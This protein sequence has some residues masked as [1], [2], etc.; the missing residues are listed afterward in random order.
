ML[1]TEFFPTP[2]IVIRDMVH[3]LKNGFKSP[4]LEPHG[5]SGAILDY[6]TNPEAFSGFS[7]AVSR[8]CYTIEIDPELRLILQGKGYQVIGS[9]FLDYSE[10]ATFN[11][12]LMN[13]PFSNG[14]KHVMKGWS[15]LNDGGEMVALLNAETVNNPYSQDRQ[16]LVDL[17]ELYG[18][19]KSLGQC[20]KDADRTTNVEV[21]CIWL[22]K[23]KSESAFDFDA[24]KFETDAIGEEDFNPN[25]LAFRDVVKDLVARYETC[26][27]VLQERH[28][29]QKMLNACLQGISSNIQGESKFLS[30]EGSFN[31]QLT[32]LKSRFWNTVFD[33]TKIGQKTT[34]KYRD[35]FHQAAKNQAHMAFTETNIK[36]LLMMFMC[37]QQSIM[38]ECLLNVFDEATRFHAKNIVH[39]E[40]WVTNKSSR[41]NKRIIHPY[42]VNYEKY[43]SGRFWL[44]VNYNIDSFLYDMDKV[45]CW[46][47]GKD[48][49]FMM[50]TRRVLDDFMNDVQSGKR[51]FTDSCESMFFNMRIY[52]KGTLHLD[53]KDLKLLEDFNR[54]VAKGKKW[55]GSDY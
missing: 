23:P 35:K 33:K 28:K 17:I 20:F 45:L 32:T 4:L 26:V 34:S 39:S 9:D 24:L 40:G 47:S 53:F 41:L 43:D 22:K 14:V 13:P 12:I 5:G 51:E 19:S 1:E 46:L 30:S 42:G 16:N 38:D 11:T 18:E 15:L 37:N 36:E 50:P 7:R 44:K 2:T 21:I 48:I 8:N 29:Q 25:G 52:K 31:E 54:A 55:I 27:R 6:I 10:P 3:A 49:D